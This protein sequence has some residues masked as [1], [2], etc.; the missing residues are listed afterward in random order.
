VTRRAQDVARLR[1]LEA[2][3]ASFSRNRDF[4]F[5]SQ[6]QN[7]RARNLRRYLRTLAA[8]VQQAARRCEVRL[9]PLS[10]DGFELV[11][12]DPDLGYRRR[13]RMSRAEARY[14]AELVGSDVGP[15]FRALD[16]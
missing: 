12:H 2:N 7:R 4:A 13:V 3:G 9:A 1:E 11:I 10:A 16:D 8:E 15:L 6:P 5:Y 14:I